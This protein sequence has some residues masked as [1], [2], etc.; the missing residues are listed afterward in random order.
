MHLNRRADAT[1]VGGVFFLAMSLLV[2]SLILYSLSTQYDLTISM[3][4]K[5]EE[6]KPEEIEVTPIYTYMVTKNASIVSYSV[7]IG[8][9]VDGGSNPL[10]NASDNDV[11]SIDAVKLVDLDL[12]YIRVPSSTLLLQDSEFNHDFEYWE[13]QISPSDSGEWSILTY[14]GG[15][16]ASHVIMRSVREKGHG[17]NSISGYI[18]QNFT[19]QSVENMESM[20]IS[21]RYNASLQ[22]SLGG[23]GEVKQAYLKVQ[24]YRD[25][26]KVG[27][28]T[29]FN[30]RHQEP[31]VVTGWNSWSED[32][33]EY[34]NK[35]GDYTLRLFVKLEVKGQHNVTF[36]VW[37]DKVELNFTYYEERPPPS[38]IQAY[39]TE[40]Y[41]NITGLEN[42]YNISS[43][44]LAY[45]NTSILC[46][47]YTRNSS[48]ENWV[49][50]EIEYINEASWFNLSFPGQMIRLLFSSSTPFNVKLDYMEVRAWVLN[51]SGL[52]VKVYNKGAPDVRV[53]SVWVNN[54]RTP[55][56]GVWNRWMLSTETA[57]LP[58]SYPLE[59]DKSYVIRVV[60]SRDVYTSTFRT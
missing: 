55:S 54:T 18:Q 6:N 27:D 35:A 13:T 30:L 49:L 50:K 34:F 38:E 59:K 46:N 14:N 1:A 43:R 5:I 51:T 21:L 2:I 40:V 15:D 37:I 60:T 41:F 26:K 22:G 10:L 4:E 12:E 31:G 52:Y 45:T 58:V 25:G 28:E 57:L 32:I 56:E 19:L 39:F 42:V 23:R 11:I 9:I 3:L 16:N 17:T 44:L 53:I 29:V 24:V 20:T 47:I 7:T 8:S 33:T 48:S 36:E